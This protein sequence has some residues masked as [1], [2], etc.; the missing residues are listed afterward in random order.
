[1]TSCY[2]GHVEIVRMLL[3]RGADVQAEDLQKSTALG[4]AFGGRTHFII[5]HKYPLQCYHSTDNL[6]SDTAFLILLYLTPLP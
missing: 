5:F 4:Y 6:V 3:Q 2:H 1:M